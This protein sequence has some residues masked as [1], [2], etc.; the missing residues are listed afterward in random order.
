M[1]CHQPGSSVYEI[2]QARILEWVAISFSRRSSQPR[3][4][5]SISCIFCFS[6]WSL[7]HWVIWEAYLNTL[8][9][10]NFSESTVIRANDY[11]KLN[12]SVH[13]LNFHTCSIIISPFNR[14]GNGSK[15]HCPRMLSFQGWQNW[16]T[17]SLAKNR[18]FIPMS[19]YLLSHYN[20]AN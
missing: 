16:G 14:W 10:F 12:S 17:E 2:S 8:L 11:G 20:F 6:R 18:S 3:D 19:S 15:G 4:Q 7:S 13:Q 1:D 5:T 9:G